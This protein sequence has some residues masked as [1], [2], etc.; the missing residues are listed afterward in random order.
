[1]R[2]KSAHGSSVLPVGTSI[3]VRCHLNCPWSPG[4]EIAEAILAGDEVGY[5]VQ[6]TD[7]RRV[8]PA[9]LASDYV[10]RPLRRH[11]VAG[12]PAR[13]ELERSST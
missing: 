13:R 7:S 1:M 3:E 2:T 11:G 6:S 8:L 4:F 12:L 5:R 10:R 9:I